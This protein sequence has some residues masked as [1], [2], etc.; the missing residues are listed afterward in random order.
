M[1]PN[2]IYT[3]EWKE[4]FLKIA[5]EQ[6]KALNSDLSDTISE[7]L[8]NPYL[9]KKL[10]PFNHIKKP[11]KKLEIPPN[12]WLDHSKILIKNHSVHSKRFDLKNFFTFLR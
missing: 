2:T 3:K 4:I 9:Q 12:W 6:K 7:L 5:D 8:K 11:L 1:Y 10:Y